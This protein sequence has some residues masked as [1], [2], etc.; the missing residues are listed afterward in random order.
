MKATATYAVASFVVAALLV[1]PA[2]A[3][4]APGAHAGGTYS[5]G[6]FAPSGAHLPFAGSAQAV[7]GQPGI[8]LGQCLVDVLQ[9]S[10]AAPDTA[11][12]TGLSPSTIEG[13]YGY[14]SASTAG[15]GQTIALVDAYDDPDAASDL[16]EFS[17][18]YGLPSECTGGSSPPSCFEFDKVNQTGG[19]K[20]PSSDSGW[21]LEIS[22]DIEWAHALAPAANIL[23]V[24]AASNNTSDLLAAEQYAADNAKYVSNSWG[25][26][27]F[28]GETSSDSYFTQPGVSYF[29]SSG[30]KGGVVDWPSSSPDVISVGGTSLTFTSGGSLAGE[31]A[32]SGGGGGCSSYETANTYQSTGGVNCHGMRATPDLAL[33]AN[34][35]S[36]VSVY[37]SMSYDGAS[38]WWTVGGTSAATPMVAAEAAVAGAD[39]NAE[40]VYA[41]PANI[42]FRDVTS[43]SNGYPASTGYDLATGLGAWSYTP[44][45]PTG[46]TTT[47]ASGGVT[48]SWSAPS[49]APTTEYTIWRGTASGEETTDIAT[50]GAPTMTYTD[51]SAT[52]G[53]TYYYVVQAAN[54]NG[55]GPFSNESSTKGTATFYTVTFNANGG[56]GTMTAETDNAPTALTPNAYTLTG[57]TFSGW[58]TAA[59]GLGG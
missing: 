11:S 46:L 12:P 43:G 25:A 29:A 20:L 6:L 57:Y 30:D 4:S 59:N 1:E 45:A 13:V 14:T 53:A 56:S 24:E 33:D 22:L 10:G 15:S 55:V 8:G 58:N 9:P 17:A 18:Q 37:D 48:L 52:G 51:T 34:P 35:S 47:S 19:S 42:P 49:G 5:S 26:T 23:L 16:N 28:A 54:G 27:E 39:V 40:Y 3:Q 50:V 21:D 32:W 2:A 44:G 31:A 36:G 7:C 38:G 41:S